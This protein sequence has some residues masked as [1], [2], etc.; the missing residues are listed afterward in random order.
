MRPSTEGTTTE[1]LD[2]TT[3]ILDQTMTWELP[4]STDSHEL[5]AVREMLRRT[6]N[7]IDQLLRE[8]MEALS[9]E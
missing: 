3:R 9:T 7:E 4:V 2:L 5:V 8:R 1:C 6:S